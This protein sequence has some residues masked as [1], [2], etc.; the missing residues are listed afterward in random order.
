M[1]TIQKHVKCLQIN[2][3][4]SKAASS[5]LRRRF[6]GENI[7]I[8]FIQE[9]WVNR[10]HIQGLT[11]NSCKLIYCDTHDRP[12]AALMLNTSIT[13]TPIHRFITG[14]LA[15]A[16]VEVPT[17]RGK[18]HI[19]MASAYF[20][21]DDERQPPPEEV[22][23]LIKWC[24]LKNKFFILCC[25]ANAHNVVWG[26][27][28]TNTRGEYLF[29]YLSVNNIDI[30]NRGN[31]PTFVNAIRK[32][33]LDLTLSD[34]FTTN[35]IVNWHVTDGPSMSDHQHIRFDVEATSTRLEARRI[36]RFAD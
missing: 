20:P 2:L 10:G 23:N 29:E 27:T 1:D 5:V 3:Q 28:D 24:Q 15:A 36:P 8:G 22:Q 11:D 31:K 14:D 25:D 18:R 19:V 34:P 26:S 30:I 35:I 12:R 16:I 17:E 6:I 7:A 32:E 21:G 13:F 4:H 33:V 9:P